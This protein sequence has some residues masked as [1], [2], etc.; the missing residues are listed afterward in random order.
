MYTLEFELTYNTWTD[1]TADWVTSVPLVVERGIEPGERMARIGRMTLAL[2]N[3]DGRYTPG[4]ANCRAGFEAGIGVRLRAS[5]GV[6]TYP[7]FAGRLAAIATEQ[8]AGSPTTVLTAEDDIAALERVRLAAFPLMLDAV[9]EEVID[10]LVNHSFTPPGLLAYWRLGHPAA[11]ALGGGSRLPGTLTGKA[12]A[13][14]Q[15]VFPYVGDLWPG[16]VTAARAI[17]E[18]C[19]SEGGWFFIAADGTPTFEDRHARPKRVTADAALSAALIGL[20]I[21]RADKRI[22]NAVEVIAHPR[23]VGSAGEVLWQA[24]HAIRVMPDQPRE[25]HLHYADPDQQVAWVGAETVI[26]PVMGVDYTATDQANGGGADLTEYVR[27]TLEAGAASA[28]IVLETTWPGGRE[29]RPTYIHALRL[30]GTPLRAFLPV[31]AAI[32][33]EASR[34]T[35]GRHPLSLDMP[36]QDDANVAQ[37][38]AGALLANRKDPHGWMEV[39]VEAVDVPSATSTA[40]LTHAL[41]RDV[42]D[43]LHLSDSALGLDGAACFIEHIRH[44]ISRGSRDRLAHRVTWRTSPADWEAFW[45]LGSAGYAEI[46]SAARLGY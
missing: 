16:D 28:R 36:L 24:G 41:A 21:L 3:P 25:L 37:D 12:F 30:R 34:L 22:A 19:A 26:A 27:L 39:R 15:S 40:N 33:D 10:W 35:Y 7:L 38:M 42:G 17:R 46:G 11:G 29:S 4:H 43:R 2:R 8:T 20:A 1:L 23:S 44:E 18:V 14:G 9:P 32:E 13:E 45:I 31:I 6:S 5:D